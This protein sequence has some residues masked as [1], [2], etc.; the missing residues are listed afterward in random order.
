MC[1]PLDKIA[2]KTADELLAGA[3]LIGT[4]PIDIN[5]LLKHWK[6]NKIARTF[7]DLEQDSAIKKVVENRGDILGL[8][9][10]DSDTLNAYYRSTDSLNR[11]RFTLA[12]EIA[13]CSLHSNEIKNGYI[14]Y[15]TNQDLTYTNE[16]S[17]KEL[18]IFMQR[19]V[20]ANI[21]AGELL[22]PESSLCIVLNKLK[23]P[24]L[25]ELANIFNVSK[26]VMKAR[27]DYLKK[28]YLV[29]ESIDRVSDNSESKEIWNKIKEMIDN[30]DKKAS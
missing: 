22:I 11:K 15:R 6:I 4:F 29:E 13:H 25:T 5:A 12:H 7:D 19:E 27:L 20:D 17:Y 8:V 14:E 26:E 2:N 18:P 1:K 21:F 28:D 16:D 23:Y 10:T 30:V 24:Y 9:L 3:G